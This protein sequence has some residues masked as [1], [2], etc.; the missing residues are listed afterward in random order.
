MNDWDK[1]RKRAEADFHTLP[2]PHTVVPAGPPEPL[3]RPDF[4]NS[5]PYSL[6]ASPLFTVTRIKM[7]YTSIP[8]KPSTTPSELFKQFQNNTDVPC[9]IGEVRIF[10][11]PFKVNI[12]Y[13]LLRSTLPAAA[14]A[15]FTRTTRATSYD[16]IDINSA[17]PDPDFKVQL[18]QAIA[19]FPK[20]KIGTRLPQVSQSCSTEAH[21]ANRPKGSLPRR[22]RE[23]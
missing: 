19:M 16:A 11:Q 8:A 13:S 17:K 20:L 9:K 22:G 4:T 1:E 18:K 5:R 7:L 6:Q 2:E 15:A 14:F 21:R 12:G 10:G 23:A 3:N